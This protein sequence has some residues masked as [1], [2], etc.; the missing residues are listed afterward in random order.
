MA[1]CPVATSV[2]LVH[3]RLPSCSRKAI[4]FVTVDIARVH[5]RS[6]GLNFRNI[7]TT[8]RSSTR[9]WASSSRADHSASNPGIIA[10]IRCLSS[11]ET[12]P[13]SSISFFAPCN[14]KDNGLLF[15]APFFAIFFLFSQFCP[16]KI[17]S[18]G[19]ACRIL[20]APCAFEHSSSGAQH[21]QPLSPQ[22][23]QPARIGPRPRSAYPRIPGDFPLALRS[24]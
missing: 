22:P 5:E 17:A 7:F 20:V 6:C 16:H 23:A 15:F 21:V 2:T 18:R 13:V 11:R 9:S 19:K 1:C 24:P 10:N 4:P 14:S 3:L 8:S 12:S